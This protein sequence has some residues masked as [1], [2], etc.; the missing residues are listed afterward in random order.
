MHHYLLL[1]A[2]SFCTPS[3]F[4]GKCKSHVL[5]KKVSWNTCSSCAHLL[6]SFLWHT[7]L[8]WN[9][10]HMQEY[11]ASTCKHLVILVRPPHLVRL[12]LFPEKCFNRPNTFL[13]AFFFEVLTRALE[14]FRLHGPL[15]TFNF[16][17]G[18]FLHTRP[19]ASSFAGF[20]AATSANFAEASFSAI[21][22]SFYVIAT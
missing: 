18:P 7:S 10:S 3:C 1:F 8:T 4:L 5:W 20:N 14:R 12:T 21:E 6:P 22:S 11:I 17:L 15:G 2:S 9:V 16:C 19:A 13:E